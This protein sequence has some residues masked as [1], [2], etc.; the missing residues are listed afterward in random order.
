MVRTVTKRENEMV[1][2]ISPRQSI[3]LSAIFS[4]RENFN[5]QIGRRGCKKSTRLLNFLMANCPAML[6]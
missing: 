6:Q 5:S 1:T 2:H 3:M 4:L